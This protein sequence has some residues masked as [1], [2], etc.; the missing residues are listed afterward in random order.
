[1]QGQTVKTFA[2]TKDALRLD[3][4]DLPQG[5]YF[6]QVQGYNVQKLVRQ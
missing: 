5:I 6:V 1:M 4:Q 3:I 2:L